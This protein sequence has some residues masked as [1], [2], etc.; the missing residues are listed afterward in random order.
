MKKLVLL[1]IMLLLLLSMIFSIVSFAQEIQMPD[2]EYLERA[3]EMYKEP[4]PK[5]EGMMF[6][7]EDIE[8]LILKRM[9]NELWEVKEIGRSGQGRPIYQLKY[10]NGP[11]SC[12][13]WSQMHGG[14][15]TAT[16]ALF[17]IFNFLE[18]SGDEFDDLRNFIKENMTLYII[19]MLNPDGA[20]VFQRAQ[21]TKGIDINRDAMIM[22]AP[23][24][25]VLWGAWNE[26]QADFGLN[27]H[28]K[29]VYSTVGNTPNQSILSLLSPAFNEPKHV[30]RVRE[31]AMRVIVGMKELVDQDFPNAIGRYG[32]G[33]GDKYFGDGVTMAGTSVILI[34]SCGWKND[35]EKRNHRRI[36]FKAI[37]RAWAE[38]ASGHYEKYD[39]REYFDIVGDGSALSEVI[40]RDLLIGEDIIDLE[41]AQSKSYNDDFTDWYYTSTITVTD[42]SKKFGHHE[43]DGTNYAWQQGKVYEEK[44]SSIEDITMERAWQ[45]LKDGYCAVRLEKTIPWTEREKYM[46]NLPIIILADNYNAQAKVDLPSKPSTDDEAKSQAIF[47]LANKDGLLEFAV[48]N[49]YLIDL[50]KNPSDQHSIYKNFVIHPA[51]DK[52]WSYTTVP[53]TKVEIK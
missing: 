36:N 5:L 45:L 49:G 8:P 43:V 48:V 18:G 30:N 3:F 16:R 23:E 50:S 21:V 40:I 52:Q 37:I 35:P 53:Y 13:A 6:K 14:E 32:D 22:D 7:L 25:A 2:A 24:S 39:V 10:G 15:S 17:D 33:T 1:S 11:I 28:D 38:M 29:G 31:K 42:S 41:I 4:L 51:Y 34:E 47:F 19:P 44:F 12:F 27:L 46:H 26:S 9:N 20:N